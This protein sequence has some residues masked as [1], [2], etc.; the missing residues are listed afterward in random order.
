LESQYGSY[1]TPGSPTQNRLFVGVA[2]HFG[3]GLSSLTQ[4]SGA[5]A[6]Y[7]AALADVDSTRLSLGE[8]LQ[9]DFAQ[10]EAGQARLAA[11]VASLESS[12][13]IARAW[14]RQF[15][16]GRKTWLDVMNAVREQAQL[17]GQIAD[18]KAAQLL[19]SWR[20]AIVARGVDS[21]LALAATNPK[22][23]S[24]MTMPAP[25]RAYALTDANGDDVAAI[26]LYAANKADAVNLHMALEI[27]PAKLEVGI[28]MGSGMGSG[29]GNGMGN[30]MGQGSFDKSASPMNLEGI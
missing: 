25:E 28:G 4:V 19:L 6:R 12:D 30:G 13:N 21:A 16:A 9:A 18:A 20:L 8:Q 26:P 24:G 27:D 7:A 10:A 2:S 15:I 3:A 22:E 1:N 23:A 17:E 11:L 14:N 5:Q 29:M